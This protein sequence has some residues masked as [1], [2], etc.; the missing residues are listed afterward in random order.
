[1]QD[2]KASIEEQ[3]KFLQ[4]KLSSEEIDEVFKRVQAGG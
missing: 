4:S 2:K 3:K 1:M